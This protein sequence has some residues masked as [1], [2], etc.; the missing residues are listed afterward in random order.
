[1]GWLCLAYGTAMMLGI[2]IPNLSIGRWCFV[3]VGGVLLGTGAI[4][5]IISRR[6]KKTI[7]PNPK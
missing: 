6:R 5:T 3:V 4:M 2:F 7:S 1:M